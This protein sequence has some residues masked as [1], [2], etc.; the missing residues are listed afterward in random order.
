MLRTAWRLTKGYRLCPW[1]SP[2]LRWRLETY[3]GVHADSIRFTDFLAFACR[4]L[5]ELMRYM[6]WAARME[7]R[8]G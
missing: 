3:W 1:R 6:R 5:R 7:K 4:H 2:Y 8:F